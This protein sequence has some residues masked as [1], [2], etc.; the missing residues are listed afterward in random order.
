[1]ADFKMGPYVCRSG[2]MDLFKQFHVQ[3]RI[4]IIYP[5][6]AGAKAVYKTDPIIAMS[7]ITSAMMRLSDADWDFVLHAC[8]DVVQVQQGNAWCP[9]KTSG[10]TQLQYA[11][12][13]LANLNMLLYHVIYEHFAPFIDALPLMASTILESSNPKSN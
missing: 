6:F 3:R 4:S 10:T 2:R 5:A 7:Y 9:I 1:M 11:D 12:L 8:L 13:Q